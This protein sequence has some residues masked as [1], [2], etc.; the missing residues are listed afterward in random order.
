MNIV[1]SKEVYFGGKLVKQVTCSIVMKIYI[2][3]A[4]YK[5]II[6]IEGARDFRDVFIFGEFNLIV[7][8]I[9][10]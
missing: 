4:R 5:E 10:R 2:L 6:V 7:I 8:P 3:N 1:L 9:S